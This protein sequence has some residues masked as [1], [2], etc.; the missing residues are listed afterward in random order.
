MKDEFEIGII[1]FDHLPKA[2]LTE[3]EVVKLNEA[4]LLHLSTIVI[5]MC[6]LTEFISQKFLDT[7]EY[8][9]LSIKIIV[10]DTLAPIN[11]VEINHAMIF[12]FQLKKV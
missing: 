9:H 11:F 3:E 7:F 12:G 6:L 1:K 8:L 2:H 10:F 4:I 5:D